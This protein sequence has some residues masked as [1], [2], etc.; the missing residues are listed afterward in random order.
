MEP[1]DGPNRAARLSG[2]VAVVTG[3]ASGIGLAIAERLIAEGAQ[4]AIFD[5]SD[6]VVAAERLGEN[7]LGLAVDVANEDNVISALGSAVEHFGK[8]DIVVNNA[9]VDGAI[10]PIADSPLDAFDHLMAVNLRGVFVMT[11]HAIPYL[12]KSDGPSVINISSGTVSKATPGLAPYS[13]SKAGIITMTKVGAVEYAPLGLRM[14]V[15]LPG[16]IE[17][18]LSTAVFDQDPEFKRATVAQH[19]IGHLGQPSDVAAA[20]VFLASD[21]A[22][23]ITGAEL[24][25]DGGYTAI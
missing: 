14:N 20:V 4:V 8:L 13:S 23:F 12:L 24:A 17:T 1:A 7:A 15:I 10:A 5:I 6:P 21:D 3:G 18:P 16:A 25:V 22:R 2:K 11:K 9:G 19:P